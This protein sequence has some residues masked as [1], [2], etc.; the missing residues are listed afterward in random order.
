MINPATVRL[1]TAL[2]HKL[3]QQAELSGA[4]IQT[5]KLIRKFLEQHCPSASITPIAE[6]GL[7]VAFPN[8]NESSIQHPAPHK[9]P[10]QALDAAPHGSAKSGP[11]LLFRAD[12]DALPI[13]DRIASAY[14][15]L[16]NGVGHKCGHDGHTVILCGLAMH[17][18]AHPPEAARVFLLFQPAEET[19]EG[20]KRVWATLSQDQ[21]HFDYVFALHNIPGVALGHILCKAGPITSAVISMIVKLEGRRAH[22]AEPWHAI[23]PSSAIGPMLAAA[24]SLEEH[25]G[26][27]DDFAVITPI[28]LWVGSP[29]Y[30]I[31]PADA[32]LHFT[33]RCRTSQVLAQKVQAFCS[34]IDQIAN[35][36]KLRV[37]YHQ[38]QAFES[39]VNEESAVAL[40]CEA[41]RSLALPYTE[42][43]H[44]FSWGE[45]FGLYTQH[46]KAAL[47]G[48][49][50]GESLP[51]LHEDTYDFPDALIA[52][53]VE[54]F[55]AL[56][57]HTAASHV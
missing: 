2:R 17:L 35:Q 51:Q 23:N 40:V 16:N 10:V 50:A 37:H 15:S 41:A 25:N 9:N 18:Q 1:L 30:G 36:E 46:Y 14:Q 56:L 43:E 5:Q 33:L 53:A 20:A 24:R 3:H 29:D 34:Q 49:G 11:A 31:S 21:Q 55:Q 39:C 45:D 28:H 6:T 8:L 13:Q 26:K 19:G 4:E 57:K 32:E 44:S 7:L 48:I 38:L 27:R 54:M 52:P 42:M 47:F 22:A 12:I